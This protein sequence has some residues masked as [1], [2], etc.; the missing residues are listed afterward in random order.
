MSDLLA[1]IKQGLADGSIVEQASPIVD[2]ALKFVSNTET[3]FQ[4]RLPEIYDLMDKA[5]AAGGVEKQ[6]CGYIIENLYAS[7]SEDEFLIIKK[8]ERSLA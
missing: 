7:A 6:R 5:W 4:K 1:K 3:P 2:E 8:F